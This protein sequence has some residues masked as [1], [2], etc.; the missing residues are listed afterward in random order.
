MSHFTQTWHSVKAQCKISCKWRMFSSIFNNR[1]LLIG[2]RPPSPTY[3]ANGGI[4]YL[5]DIYNDT[6]FN[7]SQDIISQVPLFSFICSSQGTWHQ[8]LPTHPL[9][10]LFAR[11][12]GT[13]DTVSTLCQFLL[14]AAYDDL[15]L[16]RKWKCDCLNLDRYFAVWSNIKDAS[17]NPVHQKVHFKCFD[18]TYLTQWKLHLMKMRNNLIFTLGPSKAPGTFLHMICD[19]PPI[20]KFSTKVASK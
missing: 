14:E 4:H 20:A 18:R 19:C 10:K 17:C 6:G 5:S 7:S 2:E 9:Y 8:P 13:R 16:H 3:W 11:Q 12:E 15:S 1:G